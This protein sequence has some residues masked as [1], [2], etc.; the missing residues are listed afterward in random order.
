MFHF[1]HNWRTTKRG[2]CTAYHTSILFRK[3]WTEEVVMVIQQ[4][5]KCLKERAFIIEIDGRRQRVSV[6]HA[7]KALKNAPFVLDT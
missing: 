1:F 4:C 3:D 2:V 5:R 7:H 6:E